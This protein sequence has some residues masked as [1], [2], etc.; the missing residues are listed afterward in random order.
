MGHKLLMSETTWGMLRPL[1]AKKLALVFRLCVCVR[2]CVYIWQPCVYGL[3]RGGSCPFFS[4]IGKTGV[5]VFVFVYENPACILNLC[6]FI[7]M[8]FPVFFCFSF[9]SFVFLMTAFQPHK[10]LHVSTVQKCKKRWT[11]ILFFVTE[12]GDVFRKRT[13]T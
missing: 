13:C 12:V 7:L 11:R 8:S 9:C 6:G 3:W 4:L 1:V 10:W 2:A 5:A